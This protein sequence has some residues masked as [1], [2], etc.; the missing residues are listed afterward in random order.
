LREGFQKL[1]PEAGF[2]LEEGKDDKKINCNWIID[3]LDQTKKYIAKLPLF[4]VQVGLLNEKDECILSHIYNPVAKQLFSASRGNGAFLNDKKF[5]SPARDSFEKS[6]VDVNFS[7]NSDLEW[8]IEKFKRLAQH[9]YRV[10]IS[11]NAFSPY[12]LTGAV[13]CVV[14]LADYKNKVDILPRIAV[15]K[16]A[17]LKAKYL[18]LEGRRVWLI[19]KPELFDKT[20][21]L[22]KQN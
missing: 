13:D 12:V 22:L 11:S 15:M 8:K 20:L 18:E 2:I 7:G 9:F 14:A 6:M 4:F 16:E 21:N 17:G 19:A 1:F 10:Q 5:T 3:P